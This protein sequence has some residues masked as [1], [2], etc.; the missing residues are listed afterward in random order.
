[1]YIKKPILIISAILLILATAIGT[2]MIINPFGAT[3]FWGLLKFGAGVSALENYFYEDIEKEELVD[4]ALL[5]ISYSAED[6]YTVYMTKSEAETFLESVE[7]DDY[8]GVGLYITSGED[9][10]SIEVISPLVESPAEK[11]GIA[12][13]DR[14]I[15]VDGETV[16]G[17]TIDQVAADMKG[18]EGTEVKLTIIKKS[19]GETVEITLVRAKIKRDTVNSKMLD[20]ENAYIQ[21]S[22]FGVNTYDE[23]VK[24]YNGL[25]NQGMKRLVLDLRNNPGGYMEVA[26]NIADTFIDE[27]EI[28][29][30]L[31]KNGEKRDY[32]ATEGKTKV[33]L[34]VL[35]NGGSA[36]A[37]EVLVGALRDYGL[38]TIVGEKTFGKGVTQIPYQFRDGSILKI[39]DSR[40]YTPKGICIDHEGIKP[41]IEVKM[42]DEDYS[43][44]SDIDIEKDRQLKKAIEILENK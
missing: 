28:V 17:K 33:P 34:V 1:M 41:D 2:V 22:Q 27:G 23:F 14:I 42:S 11:A 25:I 26:V 21:I 30:T 16:V 39:T 40:Y 20:D 10:R 12:S 32:M 37:S 43:R 5:G 15:E 29:Y 31:N 6:P 4:G 19:S 9:G 24:H 44:I 18:P 35:T 38:A 3:N 36:S 8:T 7:S 13:G